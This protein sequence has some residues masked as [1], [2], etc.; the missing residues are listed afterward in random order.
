MNFENFKCFLELFVRLVI[1]LLIGFFISPAWALLTPEQQIAKNEG[2]VF[3]HLK[4]SDFAVPYLYIAA[5]SG[6]MESQYYMGEIARRKAM[7]MSAEA[8]AWYEKAAEQGD[9]YAMFRLRSG[10]KT[11]C[12]LLDNCGSEVKSPEAWGEIARNLA[13]DRASQ[14]DGEAMFQLFLLTGKVDWL[15]KSAEVGFAEG[16]DWLAAQY[17]RG[18]GFFLTPG[19][20]EKEVE[21]LYRSAAE[22][23]YVPAIRNLR[24]LMWA[25][26]D[27]DGFRHWT[28]IAAELGD[29]E[30]TFSYAAWTAHTPNQVNYPLDLVKGY[31]LTLLIAQAE[32]GT[33]RKSYGEEALIEVAAKMTPEQIEAGIAFAEEWK[34]THP[35]LSRFLPKYGY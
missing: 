8:Q 10:D 14:G 31:G 16:Q 17:E 5:T 35:P 4:Q 2:L 6:D 1:F 28:K 13:E 19:R 34:K 29:F 23:G 18:S 7:F 20:R 32:P 33:W 3:Y 22:A 9:V 25:K 27:M 30:I 15:E 24:R 26:S 21:R 12:I 11:L